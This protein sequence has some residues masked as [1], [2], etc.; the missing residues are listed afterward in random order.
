MTIGET[1]RETVNTVT[2]ATA[3]SHGRETDIIPMIATRI[4]TVI[5]VHME[6]PTAAQAVTATTTP[7]EK[8]RMSSTAMTG[9]TGVIDHI[10]TG[11]QTPKGDALM[12]SVPTT[13]REEKVLFRTSGGCQ[14][15]GQQVHLGQSTIAGP[16]T[17]TN[18]LRSWT[19]APRRLRSLPRTP[20]LRLSVPQSRTPQRILTGTTGKHKVCQCWLR[21]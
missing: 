15:T 2:Q 17:L 13:T 11:I 4:T 5:D 21:N 8:G 16:S 12:N 6:T 1:G 20:A 9:T 10:T 18:L 14:S 19:L 3:T 7:L